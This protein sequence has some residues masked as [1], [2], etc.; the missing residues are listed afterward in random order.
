MV[1]V[2]VPGPRGLQGVRSFLHGG[3]VA[4]APEAGRSAGGPEAGGRSVDAAAAPVSSSEQIFPRRVEQRP[5]GPSL[6]YAVGGRWAQVHVPGAAPPRGRRGEVTTFTARSRLA[7]LRVVNAIDQTVARVEDFRF[8]TLTYP[9]QFPT[10]EASKRDLER[11]FKR[12]EREFG[13]VG[14]IWKLEPQKRGAPHYHLL[15]YSRSVSA[16]QLLDFTVRAWHE[17]AG[18]GDPN[19]LLF[20][21]GKL[22]KSRPCVE[23]VREWRGVASYAAKYLGAIDKGGGDEQWQHQGRYWGVRGRLLLPITYVREPLSPRAAV[24]LRRACVRFSEHQAPASFYLPGR[25]GLDGV[26][27]AGRRLSARMLVDLDGVRRLPLSAP[28]ARERLSSLL[29]R[30][31]RPQRRRWRSSRGGWSGFMPAGEF[32]RAVEWARAQDAAVGVP[33]PNEAG[34]GSSSR[35]Y[36]PAQRTAG[37]SL[38]VSSGGE[39]PHLPAGGGRRV[40]AA[41]PGSP[42]N[43]NREGVSIIREGVR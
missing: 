39:H 24:L 41:G 20:H 2:A 36:P 37:H 25:L 5:D 27:R 6:L 21:Q 10:A 43:L 33:R 1:A 29:E 31:I 23:T 7:L 34:Q 18:R 42:E 11:W 28:E 35:V 38:T 13:R 9:R 17:I 12:L 4:A 3:E 8:V 14:L 26:H 16:E 15:V 30:E 19:H 22:P 32:L 40:P